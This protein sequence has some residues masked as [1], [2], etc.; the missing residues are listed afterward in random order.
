M[1]GFI[2]KHL[3]IF[4]VLPFFSF[5]VFSN[6]LQ[7]GLFFDDEELIYRN[8]Y[9]QN[10]SL[11]PKFFVS[12]MIEG[13][14]KISNMYRPVLMVTFGLDYFFWKD[15][16]LGFHLTNFLIHSL[17]GVLIFL[18]I[19]IIFKKRFVAFLTALLFIVHPIQTEA[20]TYASGR[21]DPLFSFFTL[22]GA[23]LFYNYLKTKTNIFFYFG[24]LAAFVLGLLSKET[25][26]VFPSLLFLLSVIEEKKLNRGLLTKTI[27]LLFPFIII[28]TVYLL[29]RLTTLN[30][31]DTL[32]FYQAQNF[33]SS[34]LLVRIYTFSSAFWQ[35]VSVLF[36]PV[37]LSYFR[38]VDL[39]INWYEIEFLGFLAFLFIVYFLLKR[40]ALQKIWLFSFLWFFIS[41]F[42]S[43]GV[44]P[45]NNIVAEHYLYLPSVGFFLAISYFFLSL[46]NFTKKKNIGLI[47]YGLMF[48][49]IFFLGVRTFIRNTDW[50]DP[51]TF[52]TKTL[53]DTFRHAPMHNNLAMAYVDKGQLDLA[54]KEYRTAIMISDNYSQT[55]HNLANLY[56]QQKKYNLAEEEYKKALK[57]DPKFEY[58]PIKL[59]ELYR[60]MNFSEEEINKKLQNILLSK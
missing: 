30:F 1:A 56:L 37:K 41:L 46:L 44:I 4:A 17:N 33:Y 36:W 35:Y 22:L 3:L 18:L 29:L 59:R 49:I 23:L 58:S 32:N 8:V 19:E 20:V 2:K 27:V 24:S 60:K 7:N 10:P 40:S 26:I 38:E 15:N 9:V 39:V 11:W 6:G 57:I 53:K 13:A 12:N 5:L 55:H 45:I 51:I 31:I 16:S 47:M 43:S 14:G 50:K 25:A 48:L 42:P 34:N 21:T 28:S 52:Y 54:E